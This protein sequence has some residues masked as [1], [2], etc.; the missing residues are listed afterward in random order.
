MLHHEIGRSVGS[1]E[2]QAG[3]YA[4]MSPKLDQRF[5]LVQKPDPSFFERIDTISTPRMY[6]AAIARG[7]F[8]GQKLFYCN[9]GIQ[10]EMAS[11][12]HDAESA[13]PKDGLDLVGA[14]SGPNGKGIARMVMVLFRTCRHGRHGS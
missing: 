7:K 5:S 4:G 8:Q 14:E 9:N 13:V 11:P 1:E 6:G 12:V 3:D 2:L 10:L